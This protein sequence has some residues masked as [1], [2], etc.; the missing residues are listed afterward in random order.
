MK[1]TGILF[2]LSAA[3]F[4]G[5]SPTTTKLAYNFN[6]NTEFA[7]IMRYFFAIIVLA[8]FLFFIKF[9]FKLIIK[10]ILG[11]IIISI[12]ALC[13]TV[14]LLTS[15]TF[16]PVSL[17]ALIF[18]TYPLFIL[19]YN[20][21]LKEKVN[22]I[23]IIGFITAFIGLILALGPSFNVLN[24]SGILFAF[25]ASFGATTLI[26]TN[27]HLSKFFN[28]LTI[29]TFINLF[30]LLLIGI[31]IAFKFKI[32]H[33]NTMTGWYYLLFASFCYAIAFYMQLLAVKKIGSTFTALLLYFEPIVAIIAAIVLL[34]ES[35]TILQ[36]TGTIVVISSLFVT[37]L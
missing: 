7:V 4:F 13:L 8:P 36:I 28:A 29:N 19:S 33:P 16:I 2:A 22:Q 17:T 14:G 21:F 35:L 18:Y 15:V 26:I 10:H 23:Q 30:C 31:I 1:F 27:E 9:N 34:G 20:F 5:L 11:L 32:N 12:G 3:F 37:S 24:I 25:L 6:T